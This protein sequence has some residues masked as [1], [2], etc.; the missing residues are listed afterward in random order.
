MK[1]TLMTL[2]C[3]AGLMGT[4]YADELSQAEAMKISKGL[5]DQFIAAFKNKQVDKMVALFDDDGWRITD[6]GP[7]VGK[8][9]LTKHFDAVFKVADL[10]NSY[11]DQIK[12][13]DNNN[14]LVTGHWEATLRLPDQRPQP[15][16]GFWVLAIDKQKDNTWKIAMEGYNVK[17]PNPPSKSQ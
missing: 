13:L 10:E 4:A 12:V 5:E 2:V 8:D 7:V 17:M 9:A 6:M 15:S 16:T 14:I 1:R 3:I 11:P